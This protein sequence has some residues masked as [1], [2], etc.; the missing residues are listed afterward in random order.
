MIMTVTLKWARN[1]VDRSAT[2]EVS[3]EQNS[4]KLRKS[5]SKSGG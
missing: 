4:A 3:E 5:H 1:P 2:N